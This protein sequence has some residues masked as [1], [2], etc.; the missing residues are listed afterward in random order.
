LAVLFLGVG[1]VRFLGIFLIAWITILFVM[2]GVAFVW[3]ILADIYAFGGPRAL[4]IALMALAAIAALFI[5]LR[6]RNLGAE[7]YLTS[8][9]A[10]MPRMERWFL[11]VGLV[12][13]TAII[14]KAMWNVMTDPPG[15]IRPCAF[16]SP[17]APYQA[18][19]PP[20]RELQK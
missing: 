3:A 19:E 16:C 14:V 20:S 7:Q 10:A 15:V 8:Y 17:Y 2:F 4:V 13:V 12:G 18:P 6:F 1:A 11:I 5:A 9:L